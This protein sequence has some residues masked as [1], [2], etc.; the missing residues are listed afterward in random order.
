MSS[1]C[2]VGGKGSCNVSAKIVGCDINFGW[3]IYCFDGD[4]THQAMKED[5][6]EKFVYG[7]VGFGF[8]KEIDNRL[9][10]GPK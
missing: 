3:D 1:N 7:R 5:M 6:P 8:V 4:V 9:V 2:V 10:V